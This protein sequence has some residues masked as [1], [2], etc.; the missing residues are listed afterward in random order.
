[1]I[2]FRIPI[3]QPPNPTRKSEANGRNQCRRRLAR[4]AHDQL[5]SSAKLYPPA[6]GKIPATV[7]SAHAS[8]IPSHM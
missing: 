5:G 4:K 8:R 1:M 2:M 7:A 6:I 3:A